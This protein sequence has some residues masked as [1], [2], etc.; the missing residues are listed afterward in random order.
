MADLTDKER[1]STTRIVG[2]D[3]L[4]AADVIDEG[5]NKKLL[6]KATSIPES[7]GDLFFL[8]ALDG[9]GSDAMNIDGS[10]TP[11][12]FELSAQASKDLVT[13]ELRFT[14]FDNGIKINNFLGLN[15][16]LTNGIT[17]EI[18]SEDIVSM[19][20]AIMTTAD[21]DSHFAFGRSGKFTREN[22]AGS[23]YMSAT[24]GPTVPFLIRKQGTFAN[25]D[26][27]RITINDD[28]TSI[29]SLDFIA[30]GTEA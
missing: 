10:A 13:Q 19:F 29:Q 18:K 27:I 30:F 4:F 5:G 16:A 20:L 25:D 1:S 22:S 8:K 23:D 7:L 28:L 21:F 24:F 26:Y 17:I 12:T 14:A 2:A 15:S 3:E 9:A 11:V 6:V